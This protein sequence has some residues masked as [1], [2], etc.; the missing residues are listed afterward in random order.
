MARERILIVEDES[1]TALHLQE[2]LSR[3]GYHVPA[4]ASSGEE[5]VRLA[6]ELSPDLVL[7]DVKLAGAMNG[8]D[9]SERIREKAAIPIV[10]LTA[11]AHAFMQGPNRMQPPK[12]CI[13]KPF[14]LPALKATIELALSEP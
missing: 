6:H 2:H 3:L 13:T 12:I 8:V 9:A 7:M 11:Y 10:Y 14:S 1:V 5:A 4:V